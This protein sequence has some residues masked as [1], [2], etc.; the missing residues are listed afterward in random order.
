DVFDA[1]FRVRHHLDLPGIASR[2]RVAPDGRVG[3]S[4]VFVA[5]D[6]YAS[7]SF[8]TRTEFFDLV[9]GHRITDLEKF[10]VTHDGKVVDNTDRNYWGVTFAADSNRFYATL[11]TGGRTYLIRGNLRERTARV[12]RDDV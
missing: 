12:I 2:A 6:S 8:S 4:T 1:R 3:A 7:A 11:G 10:R 9:H 5:G